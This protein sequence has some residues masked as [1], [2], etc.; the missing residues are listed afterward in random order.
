MAQPYKKL[1]VALRKRIMEIT[2]LLSGL[3]FILLTGTSFSQNKALKDHILF[4]SSFDGN[5]TA[6]V[7]KGDQKIY[8]SKNYKEAANAKAGLTD[9]YVVLAK[10]KGL[11]GDAIHFKQAKTAAVFYKAFKNVGYSSTSW[12]GTVSFW[13]R[14]DPNNELPDHYC[15]PVVVT[16]AQWNDAA[17]WVDFT[18]HTPRQFRY[19]AMG[20]KAAWNANDEA[21]DEDWTK[22]T[23]VV[24][25]APFASDSW[26]HVAMVF[27]EVN[28]KSKFALYL[29]AALQGTIENVT[30]NPF[31]W[32]AENGKIM[33][34]LGY[35]GFMD[36]LA[37]FNK[38]LNAEEIK[39]VYELK[40]GLSTLY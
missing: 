23:V 27:S 26:T 18:D 37:V 21:T 30:N 22:R 19:G 15:D 9:P 10:G 33:L 3:I 28:T 31:S 8:T 20:D 25:P 39:A 38:A 34:G 29:N 24:N 11:A 1:S 16:D 40:R 32:E 36:E 13:L 6:D 5:L 4:Y 7:A 14:L 2:K 12:S 35:V 17:L